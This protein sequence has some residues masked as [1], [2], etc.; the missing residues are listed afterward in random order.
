VPLTDEDT[1]VVDRLGEAELVDLGL[2][3]ALHEVL[4]LNKPSQ[5]QSWFFS[6]DR[7]TDLEGQY[8]I[9]THSRLVQHT[10]SD[11]T[12]DQGVTL[13][14]SLGVLVIKLEQFTGSTADLGEGEG[15][16]PNLAL[17]LESVLADDLEFGVEAGRLKGS[18][19]D[20]CN[21]WEEKG[22]SD[23][24]SF[25]RL[26]RAVTDPWSEPADRSGR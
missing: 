4:D 5:T 23:I 19:R 10:D 7:G 6:K 11:Q 17:V 24:G 15:D 16:A 3:A 2:K 18:P 12:P 21:C 25:K 9:E 1:G 26:W 8:V 13:E 14:Q 22:G 20:F